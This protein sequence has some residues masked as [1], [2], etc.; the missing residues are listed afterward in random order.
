MLQKVSLKNQEPPGMK[1]IF[2]KLIP[3]LLALISLNASAVTRYVDLN[4]PSPTPPY[5]SWLTAATNIQDAIDA[6]VAGDLVLVTNGIYCTGGKFKAGDLTNRV[7]IDKAIT[8]QSVNGWAFTTIQGQKDPATNGN[9]AVRCVWLTNSASLIGFTLRDGATRAT[10]DQYSL[11]SGGGVWASG[12]NS[13]ISNCLIIENAAHYGGGAYR[14]WLENCIIKNNLAEGD[15]GGC[16]SNVLNR[17]LITENMGRING[18]GMLGGSAYNSAITMNSASAGGGA[19]GSGNLLNCTITYN[20]G[21]SIGGTYSSGSGLFLQNC[22]IWANLP[23]NYSGSGPSFQ[24]CCT[25]PNPGVGLGNIAADPLLLSDGIHIS[26]NSPCRNAGASIATGNDFD[27][28]TWNSPPAIGCDEWKPEPWLTTAKVNVET[29]GRV[30]LS[31]IAIGQTP[32]TYQWVKDGALLSDNGKISGA[33]SQSLTVNTISPSDA[34][35]YQLIAS[36]SLGVATGQVTRLTMRFVDQVGTA[37]SPPYTNWITAATNIQDAVDSAGIGDVIVVNN[38]IYGRGGKVMAGDLTNR[39]VLNKPVTLMSANGPTATII[40]GDW[41]L[42]ATNGLGSVRSVWMGDNS[43]LIG[44]TIRGGATRGAVGDTVNLQT[45]GGIWCNSTN[46]R[47]INCAIQGNS[48]GLGGGGGVFRGTLINS[49]VRGNLSSSTGGGTSHSSLLNCTV[50]ENVTPNSASGTG[51]YNS[52]GTNLNRN[53]I[54]WGNYALNSSSLNEYSGFIFT[55]C[56]TRPLPTGTG[57]ISTDPLFQSDGFHLKTGSPCIGAGNSNFVFGFDLDGQPWSS[58]PAMGCDQPLSQLA[59]GQPAIVPTG[60]GKIG[61]RVSPVGAAADNF[62]WFKDGNQITN[63]LWVTGASTAE[64]SIKSFVPLDAGFYHA[65]ATNSFGSATSTA[66]QIRPRFVDAASTTPLPPFTNW[67]TAA[68]TI[69]DAIDAADFG[70]LIVVADGVYSVGGK[71]V[72]GDLTNRVGLTKAV[73]VTSL[74]GS[75]NAIIEGQKDDSTANGNGNSAV[76][77]VWMENWS[78]LSGFTI[79]NGATRQTGTANLLQSGGGIWGLGGNSLTTGCIITNNSAQVNGG[80]TYGAVLD[81][82]LV[83]GNTATNGGGVFGGSADRTTIIKNRSLSAQSSFGS[84]GAYNSLLRNSIVTRNFVATNV[85][86]AIGGAGGCTLYNCTITENDGVGIFFGIAYNTISWGNTERDYGG[87]VSINFTCAKFSGGVVGTNNLFV[88]PQLVDPFHITASSPCRSAGGPLFISGTDYDGDTWLSPVSIGADEFISGSLTGALS[89]TIESPT[90]S[91]LPNRLLA[92]TGRVTGRASRIEWSFGD[93]P[94]V[95]NISYMTAH[96]WSIPGDYTVT[97]T[98]YNDS[99]PSGVSTT[100]IVNV[101]AIESPSWVSILKTNN[102]FRFSFNTQ[103]GVSNVIDY[104]TNLSPP[105]IWIPLK[106]SAATNVLMSEL[107]TNPTN[108]TRFYR[109]RAQ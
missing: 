5:T 9:A 74:N 35:E 65:I 94:V 45:G 73:I 17:C 23:G 97:F 51:V 59:L 4:S 22:I 107:D 11:R 109:L 108:A 13:L 86:Y 82:C 76:R 90:N 79:R 36:N 104:A 8:V 93:G 80:G 14:G 26:S 66:V 6:A 19:Y 64:L 41:D 33:N 52:G 25:T 92:F 60:D 71:V 7:A 77:A 98:A 40:Q 34:G 32:F 96:S 30:R 101:V 106:T 72:S 43:S 48:A 68:L 88:D 89:L 31:A 78:K 27:G 75:T 47:V 46:A 10:G 58:P 18:G 53:T 57:N 37:P 50:T 55:N 24:N 83:T 102:S 95:T 42:G 69:Q 87:S 99:N 3:A 105:V 63:D 54:I 44:F 16:Y 84:G 61:L 62:W 81:N 70:D 103:V 1:P 21:N 39:V 28:Q 29:W 85:S 15:G 100:M 56:N 67:T 38:G 12:T 91:V 49:L 2:H 20:R